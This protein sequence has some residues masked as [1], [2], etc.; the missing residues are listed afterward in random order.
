M[1]RVR[2]GEDNTTNPCLKVSLVVAVARAGEHSQAHRDARRRSHRDQGSRPRRRPPRLEETIPCMGSPLL[3]LLLPASLSCAG[4]PPPPPT[5]EACRQPLNQHLRR[6][7]PG[8]T[9]FVGGQLGHNWIAGD[10]SSSGVVAQY[11]QGLRVSCGAPNTCTRG[12]M[13]VQARRRGCGG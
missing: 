13:L 11:T 10:A 4:S 2:I 6:L 9:M 7:C 1:N 5:A 12:A 3:L 8:H